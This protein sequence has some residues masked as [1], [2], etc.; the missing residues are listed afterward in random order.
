MKWPASPILGSTVLLLAITLAAKVI[1]YTEKILLANYFGTSGEADAYLAVFTFVFGIFVMFRELVEPGFLRVFLETRSENDQ[2]LPW[3]FF[4]TVFVALSILPL[5]LYLLFL[6]FPDDTVQLFV[7]GFEGARRKVTVQLLYF[8]F[9][10]L[11]FLAPSTLSYIAL[12]G[13]KKFAVPAI[14][15]FLFKAAILFCLVALHGKLG[16]LSTG[17]GILVGGACRLIVIT[18]PLRKWLQKG[19]LSLR[20]EPVRKMRILT[21]PL[22]IGIIFSQIG[23]L[24]DNALASLVEEGALS[25]LNYARKI[26]EMPVVVFPYTLG[27]VLFPYLSQFS[28][29]KDHPRQVALLG[30]SLKWITLAFLPAGLFLLA[31][32]P[33]VVTVLLMRGAFDAESVR[34]TSG[35]LMGYSIGLLS[36]AIET[37]LVLFYFSCGDTKRPVFIGMAGVAVHLL[38]GYLFLAPLGHPGIALAFSI[39][40]T[41]KVAVLL[42]LLHRKIAVNWLFVWRFVAK[43]AVAGCAFL[44]VLIAWKNLTP[45]EMLIDSW[46]MLARLV[47]MGG[48]SG[49]LFILLLLI[50]KVNLRRSA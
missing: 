36:F 23:S 19:R 48:T 32:A 1:G 12:N 27:I 30:D 8:S 41:F 29:D 28:I 40:K 44:L 45:L 33:E 13:L 47:M 15:D 25:A 5:V 35:A 38:L 42:L 7:P 11:L 39:S 49:A 16:I 14:G 3:K 20:S 50:M 31:C 22:V 46:P 6:L 4:N 34:L 43:T 10:A 26:A 9:P 37:V 17:L 18:L 24:F 21:I 2:S